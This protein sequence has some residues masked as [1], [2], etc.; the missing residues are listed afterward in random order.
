MRGMMDGGGYETPPGVRRALREYLLLGSRWSP[1][2]AFFGVVLRSRRLALEGLYDDEAWAASSI[3]I[4][5][6]LE[7]SGAVF[8]L[9]GFDRLREVEGPCVIVANHMSTLETT[10]LPGLVTPLKK[11]TFVVKESLVKGPVWGPIMRSRVPIV[12]TR[13]N[14]RTDLEAVLEGGGAALASGRSVIVFPQGSRSDAFDREKF[15]SIG[16]KL[17]SRAGVPLLPVA[18]KTDFWGNG[19]LLRGF[20]KVRRT[21]PIM[22]EFGKA[23]HVAGRGKTEHEEVLRFIESKLVEWG[24]AFAPATGARDAVAHDALSRPRS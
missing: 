9:S 15:N 4:L 2:F 10:L 7:R 1:Y 16:V 23:I 6:A 11:C 22:L 21:L 8:R 13:K 20:G 14:P 3:E 12:V 24:A 5:R 18:L 19:K 17:A